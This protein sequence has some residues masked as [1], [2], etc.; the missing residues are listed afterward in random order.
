[1]LWRR[2]RVDRTAAAAVELGL[3]MPLLVTIALACAD[4]GRFAHGYI[5]VTNAAR[6]GAGHGIMNPFTSATHATWQ[7]QVR[8]AVSNEMQQVIAS[9]AR[10]GADN[11]NVTATRVFD[12]GAAGPWRVRVDVEYPFETVVHWPLLPNRIELRRRVEM[13]G[14]R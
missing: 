5:A 11:L 13:R 9:D 8:Q 10:F 12:S 4:L 3:L 6:A 1:M 14:I 2:R 7:A